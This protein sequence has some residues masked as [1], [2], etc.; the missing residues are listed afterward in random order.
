MTETEKKAQDIKRDE[1]ERERERV[2]NTNN[3]F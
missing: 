2:Y 1:R 3:K